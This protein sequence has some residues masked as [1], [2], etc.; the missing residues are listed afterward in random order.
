MNVQ[1]VTPTYT[2]QVQLLN[3]IFES[4]LSVF[5]QF[6]FMWGIVGNFGI[7]S[8]NVA[9]WGFKLSEID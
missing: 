8:C 3:T 6:P 9:F 4:K 5:T 1:R 2:M 7:K